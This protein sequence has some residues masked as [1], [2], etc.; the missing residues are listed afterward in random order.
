MKNGY[1]KAQGIVFVVGV[2]ALTDNAQY[3]LFMTGPSR[4]EMNYTVLQNAWVSRSFAVGNNDR[5]NFHLY[6]WFNWGQRDF[7][8]NVDIIEG[9]VQV[10]MNSYSERSFIG[11]GFTQIPINASNSLWWTQGITEN[12]LELRVPKSSSI[13]C[14]FCY[15]YLMVRTNLTN[16]VSTYR[17]SITPT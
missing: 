12:K 3:T 14:Y 16:A 5:N 7:K 4:Y 13:F 6:R 1:N 8:I 9:A 15:Y 11:S 2:K 17:V 10:Y